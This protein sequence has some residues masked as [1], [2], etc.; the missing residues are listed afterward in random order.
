MELARRVVFALIILAIAAGLYSYSRQDSDR[1]GLPQLLKGEK[2]P[3]DAG[4]KLDAEDVRALARMNDAFSKL[5]ASVLPSVVSITTRKVTAGQTMLHPLLGLVPGRPEVIPGL[6][7]G[8]IISKDGLVV[9][10]YHVVADVSELAVTT[11][12]NQIFSAQV[13]GTDEERDIALL[14]IESER[15]DF[16]ALS[17]GDSDKVKVG[18]MVF[19][20][21]NPFGLSGTVTQ[22]IISARDRHLSDSQMDY[23]Q[24]DTVINP[25]NSGGP[26]VDIHGKIVGVNVAIYRGDQNVRAWQGVGLSVPANGVKMVVTAIQQA[27][28]LREQARRSGKSMIGRGYL[29][30]EV[31]RDPIEIDNVWGTSPIGALI[32]RV[33]ANSP[34]A[35]SGL[36]PGDVVTKFQGMSFRMPADLLQIILTQPPGTVVKLEVIRNNRMREVP[37]RLGERPDVK[38]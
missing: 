27:L 28:E 8:A 13:L 34:A 14:R 9:T 4:S 6:G 11:N 38:N 1:Y 24:T 5:A 18:E 12:D 16:P 32:S 31:I 15:K 26:L 7:S 29:G 23:L 37:A 19:A 2:V 20:V 17:F 21:G 25:G 33:D 30:I 3:E 36:K 35:V 10:N 22:G